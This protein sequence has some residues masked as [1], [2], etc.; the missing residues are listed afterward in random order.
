MFIQTSKLLNTNSRN[1]TVCA[2]R[3]I[4]KKSFFYKKKANVCRCIKYPFL[5]SIRP[6][7]PPL[8][9][10]T[11]AAWSASTRFF[12]S[13]GGALSYDPLCPSVGQLVGWSIRRSIS[14]S[15]CYSFLTSTLLYCFFFCP[16]KY[17]FF[18]PNDIRKGSKMNS[19]GENAVG[20]TNIQALH[21]TEELE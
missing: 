10:I 17:C 1:Q 9:S 5:Y 15:V 13:T 2:K 19:S 14:R 4:C 16:N 11:P 7:S 8:W 12:L 21:V 3:C 6:A 20:L 18:L